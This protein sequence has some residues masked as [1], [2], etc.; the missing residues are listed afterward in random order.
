ML[1]QNYPIYLRTRGSL[2]FSGLYTWITF[3]DQTYSKTYKNFV[4]KIQELDFD[5]SFRDCTCPT[6][7]SIPPWVSSW[8]PAISIDIWNNIYHDKKSHQI[9]LAILIHHSVDFWVFKKM[10]HA[11]SE[12]DKKLFSEV[13]TSFFEKEKIVSTWLIWLTSCK[14][15]ANW[16]ADSTELSF[17]T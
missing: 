13:S 14:S 17:M 7:N 5:E 3:A 4:Y 10:L 12:K 15:L 9:D 6:W 2:F 8:L 11:Y 16:N 1:G